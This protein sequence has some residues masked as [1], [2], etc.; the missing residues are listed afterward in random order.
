MLPLIVSRQDLGGGAA[1][2]ATRLGISLNDAGIQI[3]M[4]VSE[5]T[6]DFSWVQGSNG[7]AA[8]MAARGRAYAGSLFNRLQTCPEGEVRSFNYLPFGLGRTISSL[9]NDVVNLHWI[10]A[11]TLSIEA[12]GRIAKPVVWTLHD[13]WAFAGAE[14]YAPDDPDARWRHSYSRESRGSSAR[15]WDIDRQVWLRKRKAWQRPRHVVCPTRWLARC[16][17]ESSLMRTWPIHVIPNPLDLDIFR[18]W[19][20]ALARKML[21]LPENVPLIGFGAMGGTR[22]P[23]KGWDLL[24]D[25]LTLVRAAGIGA[26][27]VIF[28]QSR[29]SDVSEIPLPSHWTGVLSDEISIALLYNAVDIIVVPSRQDNL[30]QTATEPQACGCPVVAFDI[31]GLP[32]TIEDGATGLLA[33]PFDIVDLAKAILTLVED[34]DMRNNFARS[35]RNRAE[36]SWNS[37]RITDAYLKIYED[38]IHGR[39]A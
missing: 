11:D 3:R 6:S 17:G 26:E 12:I 20:K 13:M 27:A 25:A 16:A 21:G 37:Q 7:Y 28:G 24:R 10:G 29:P 15:G 2:A 32:D 35:A 30:P 38:A 31:A 36:A 39:V 5:K 22:D 14:H 1:R 18:P 23:R 9:P 4:L 34:D 33:R 19:P 8:T